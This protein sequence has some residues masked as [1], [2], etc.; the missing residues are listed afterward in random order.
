MR[1]RIQGRKLRVSQQL[2]AYIEK[3]ISKLA[4][5]LPALHEARVELKHEKTRDAAQSQVVEVTLWSNGHILR[6]EERSSEFESAV[7]AVLEKLYRQ[8]DHWK[9]KQQRSR[10]QPAESAAEMAAA[11]TV[12][13]RKRF[14]VRPMS[15]EDALEQME[16]LGHSFF[17]FLN[18]DT[19]EV[20]LVY[21]REDGHYGVIEPVVEGPK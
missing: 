17:L 8:I 19:A 9:G 18:R 6:G 2:K 16:L 13:K 4:H 21:R 14:G 10:H 20:N 1:L 12:I 11:G 7:D 5:Y 15:E 3:K